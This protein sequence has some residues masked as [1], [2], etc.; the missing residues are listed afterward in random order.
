MRRPTHLR[1]Q[2]HEVLPAVQLA[3]HFDTFSVL[4]WLLGGVQRGRH[5]G[6][7]TKAEPPRQLLEP[8]APPPT[9]T[10]PPAHVTEQ[11]HGRLGA[12][13]C[14]QE[15]TLSVPLRWSGAAQELGVVVDVDVVELVVDVVV[16]EVLVEVVVLVLVVLVVVVEDV[17][18][19]VVVVAVVAIV[20]V[21][22]VS[23][24]VVTVVI[25]KV[26]LVEDRVAD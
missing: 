2:K 6:K 10:L 13:G 8:S 21:V 24:V 16:V 5:S 9:R 22:V 7:S 15:E 12:Q 23:V 4:Y 20:V 26:V 18:V 17:V 11:W 25:F 3:W 14:L 1:S 19:V